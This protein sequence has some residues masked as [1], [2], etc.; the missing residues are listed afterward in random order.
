MSLSDRESLPALR[1]ADFASLA[2]GLDYAAHC[3]TGLRFYGGRGGLEHELSYASLQRSAK[4]RARQLNALGLDRASRVGLVAAMGPE[5][6]ITFYACQYAGLL[7]CPLPPMTHAGAQENYT[8]RITAFLDTA[9]AKIVISTVELLPFV[10]QACEASRIAVLSYAELAKVPEQGQLAPLSSRDDAYL[11]FSSGS[12]AQP[13]GVKI[14]QRAILANARGILVQGIGLSRNDRA[15]SWL[16]FYH[17]MGLVGFSIA[18]MLGQCSVDYLPASA[19]VR[20]PVLWLQLM[21][22]N[23]TTITYAPTF[24]YELAA[25]RVT[26]EDGDMDLS[27]LRIAGIGGDLIRP[28]AL[29]EF[30]AALAP[31]GF[32]DSS[33]RPSYGMAEATL[34]VSFG[35][36]GEGLKTEKVDRSALEYQGRAIPSTAEDAREFVSCGRALDRHEI[37]VMDSAGS[38]LPDRAVGRIMVR[39]PSLMDGYVE[40]GEQRDSPFNSEGFFDSGDLGYKV[41][42]DLFVTG[43]LKDL[44]IHHGRN[45]WPQDLEWSILKI[46]PSSTR[47]AAFSIQGADAGEALVVLVE[48]TPTDKPRHSEIAQRIEKTIAMHHGLLPRV[49]FVAKGSIP[50]TSSGKSARS[51]A[52]DLFEKGLIEIY[53]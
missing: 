13:K 52:K 30:A 40:R 6:L 53:S 33:F 2:E 24:G 32:R 27:Q 5:F 46:L 11:Q 15:F 37:V 36:N 7:A 22:R 34:A 23:T 14:S 35:G 19:F 43:R 25:R 17:D 51:I 42:Q 41:R 26:P 18:P 3:E 9:G 21:S 4:Q 38:A 49:A 28:Q 29:R 39:G 12:T 44:I 31:R 47:V 16:P 10:Q 1:L 45:I 8:S 50:H 20:R 48:S